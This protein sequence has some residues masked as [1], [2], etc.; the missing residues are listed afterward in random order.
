MD[1]ARLLRAFFLLL[2]VLVAGCLLAQQTAGT[3]KGKVTD[4][5]GA[6]VGKAKIT[7]SDSG[8]HTYSATSK[9]DGSYEITNVPAGKYTVSGTAE[10]FSV[11]GLEANVEAAKAE[12]LDVPL[13]IAVQAESVDVSDSANKVDVSN[14]SNAGQ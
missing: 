7:A 9:N 13:E 8:G 6:V 14:E 4:P 12:T 11:S 2:P 1:R 5:S 10:G 3:L